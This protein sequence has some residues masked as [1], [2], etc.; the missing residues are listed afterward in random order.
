MKK[1]IKWSG[2]VILFPFVVFIILCVL[3]YIPPIQNFLVAQATSYS[4][5]ATG[6]KIEIGRIS[7]SF[8]LDL[9]VHNV[10]VA[11]SADNQ[12]LSIKEITAEVQMLP[13][14]RKEVELDGL[15]LKKASVNTGKLIEGMEL[16][17]ELGEFHIESH[18]VAF[19]PETAIINQALLRD[20]HLSILL[21]DT[22]ASDTT[23]STP[24]YW[25]LLLKKIDFS[26]VSVQMQMPLD[27]LSF[28]ASLGHFLLQNGTVDLHKMAYQADLVRL[29]SGSISY[30]Y[31]MP[32]DSMA[33][34]LNPSHI[35]LNNIQT[36]MDSLYFCG[37]NFH[38]VINEFTF[39]EEGSGIEFISGKGSIA[40][41]EKTLHIPEFHLQTAESFI[42]I[43][44]AM[45]WDATSANPAGLL[46]AQL[47]ADF[48]K[49]DVM[50]LAGKLPEDFT[51]NYPGQP[52]RIRAGIDGNLN[53]LQLTTFTVTLPETFRIEMDGEINQ[54][55]DSIKRNGE[56]RLNTLAENMNFVKALTGGS[57]AIPYGTSLNGVGK[58]NGNT[59]DTELTLTEKQGTLKL[60]GHYDWIKEAY[61]ASIHADNIQLHNF[62]PK[63]SLF[64]LTAYL[65]AEGRGTDVFTP[66]TQLEL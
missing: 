38:A 26:N 28:S 14:L 4:S 42:D 2:M 64:H 15:T 12:I 49:G 23:A 53:K 52:L 61:A 36:Q 3:I 33:S 25:K 29:K 13:L 57:F 30:D 44:A 45:D 9:V 55:A 16:N 11:D 10:Q 54:L 18:G 20:S 43:E 19:D 5:K 37:N 32:A 47:I 8:P 17:G 62:M 34:G 58:I 51:K 40:S 22:T 65:Q 50:K 21:A 60:N 6:M 56:I 46:T 59:I 7:L 35:C 66:A 31:G 39:K 1:Y 27:S 48:S 24:L 41:N 63:D